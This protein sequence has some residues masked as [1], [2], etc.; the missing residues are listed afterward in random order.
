MSKEELVHLI[1]DVI[2]ELSMLG[3]DPDITAS[4]KKII[5]ALRDAL[6]DQQLTVARLAFKEKTKDYKDATSKLQDI[7]KSI[8]NTINDI[9]NL[10]N[11]VKSVTQL[12]GIIDTV[13]GLGTK[14]A[15]AG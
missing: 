11:T 3:A 1:G 15:G 5:D 12:I 8:Q 6:D 9:D 4:H 14:L 10:I 2:A 7:N 13:I